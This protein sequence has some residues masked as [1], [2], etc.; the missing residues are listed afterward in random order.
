MLVT[1]SAEPSHP[2]CYVLRVRYVPRVDLPTR[3][4][5]LVP[6]AQ[7]PLRHIRHLHAMRYQI[8]PHPDEHLLPHSEHLAIDV[9]QTP[10]G[11][12]SC[13]GESE[14]QRCAQAS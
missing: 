14:L 2:S 13:S 12:Q 10:N 4:L 6:A 9:D 5:S 8:V 3:L 7:L 11:D 1:H